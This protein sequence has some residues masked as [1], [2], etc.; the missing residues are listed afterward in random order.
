MT[1]FLDLVRKLSESPGVSGYEQAIIKIFREELD[2]CVDEIRVDSIGN[3]I[4]TKKSA[5]AESMKVMVEAHMDEPGLNVKY[6]ED[7]GFIRL[8]YVGLPLLQ[9]LPF[10]RVDIHGRR[11]PV[12]GVVGAPGLHVYFMEMGGPKGPEKLPALRDLFVDI[13][14]NS[15]KEAEDMGIYI[16]AQVTFH[17]K[18]ERLGTRLVTGKAFDNRALCAVAIEGIRRLKDVKHEATVYLV[19]AVQEEVA[20]RGGRAAAFRVDPDMAMILEGTIPGDYPGVEFR[21]FPLRVGGGACIGVKD[22]A[23]DFSLGNLAHPKILELLTRTAKEENIRYQ[24]ENISGTCTDASTIMI[25][26]K[27]IPCGKISVPIRYTHT[28]SEVLSLEDLESAT[29]LLVG[30]LRRVDKTFNIDFV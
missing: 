17:R 1:D 26:G 22:M 4:A 7:D 10:E 23:W 21:D 6:I 19:G 28:G 15:R 27:G 2:G 25:T 16:G 3:V 9:A 14:A 11:G 13:G 29:E 18:V 8:D 20:N 24:L 5:S 30:S 12:L